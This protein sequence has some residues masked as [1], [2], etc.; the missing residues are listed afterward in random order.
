MRLWYITV[1][2]IAE[3]C[4]DDDQQS[5]WENG[6]FDPH[7][8]ETPKIL[9]P[10]LMWIIT[11]WTPQLCQ[12]LWKSVQQ[13]VLLILLKYNLLGTLCTFPSFPFFLVIA[14]IYSKNGWTDFYGIYLKRR[15]FAQRRGFWKF[16]WKLSRVSKPSK[17]LQKV[18]EVGQFQA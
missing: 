4:C 16:W 1:C 15:R 10:K 5:Q 6:N 9:K 11:S 13:G 18:G 7:R 8:S 2:A 17:N 14:Y 12:L 3:H